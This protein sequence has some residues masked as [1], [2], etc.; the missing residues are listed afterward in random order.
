MS[1]ALYVNQIQQLNS[2]KAM[3]FLKPLFRKCPE[4]SST[5]VSRKTG[6]KN[7]NFWYASPYGQLNINT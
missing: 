3:R 2:D 5:L 6:P 7:E 1:E 4:P